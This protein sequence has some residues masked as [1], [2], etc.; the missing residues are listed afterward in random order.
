MSCIWGSSSDLILENC[1]QN[2]ESLGN[3]FKLIGRHV[4]QRAVQ[5]IL[6]IKHLNV[7]KDALP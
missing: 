6:V 5:A 3:P 7:F 4:A 1:A 2:S